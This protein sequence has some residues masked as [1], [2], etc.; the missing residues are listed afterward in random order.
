MYRM[1]IAPIFRLSK[2][3]LASKSFCSNLF[4]IDTVHFLT[5]ES[6]KLALFEAVGETYL[7][8]SGDRPW[9]PPSPNPD[10]I[11]PPDFF[12]CRS[13]CFIIFAYILLSSSLGQTRLRLFSLL[14]GNLFIFTFIRDNLAPFSTGITVIFRI[15]ALVVFW[16]LSAL[17]IDLLTIHSKQG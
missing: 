13:F 7:K 2:I 14:F 5:F 1:W 16:V 9:D 3:S 11:E 12:R 17:F 6:I 10:C 8:L 15:L 4:S